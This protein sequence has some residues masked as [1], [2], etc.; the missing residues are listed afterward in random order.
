LRKLDIR[1]CGESSSLDV[2]SVD[3]GMLDW[4]VLSIRSGWTPKEI[5]VW[6]FPVFGALLFDLI[7]DGFGSE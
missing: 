1:V 6:I 4:L 7:R 2:P 5:L 3:E